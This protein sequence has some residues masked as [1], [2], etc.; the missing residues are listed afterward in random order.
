[1]EQKIIDETY[2]LQFSNFELLTT[3]LRR[4]FNLSRRRSKR[5]N[6]DNTANEIDLWRSVEAILV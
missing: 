2:L 6:R 5:C 1:M 4:I 3:G